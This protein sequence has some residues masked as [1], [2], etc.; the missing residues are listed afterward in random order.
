VNP[1]C[2]SSVLDVVRGSPVSLSRGGAG[3]VL[4]VPPGK[5]LPPLS[6]PSLVHH[7][8]QMLGLHACVPTPGFRSHFKC[9]ITPTD[10]MNAAS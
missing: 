5:R 6:T 9:S 4:A 2:V 7:E 10:M 8:K 1:G 3:D